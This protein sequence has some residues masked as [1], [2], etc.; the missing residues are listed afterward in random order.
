MHLPLLV[1]FTKL[2]DRM[3]AD[4]DAVEAGGGRRMGNA[5]NVSLITLSIRKGFFICD[6]IADRQ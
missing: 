2:L 1:F 3:F 4:H 5:Q 6:N